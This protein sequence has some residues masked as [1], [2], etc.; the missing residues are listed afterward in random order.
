MLCVSEYV[1]AMM[2]TG[3]TT[4]VEYLGLFTGPHTLAVTLPFS[5]SHGK[6]I[7]I[8]QQE[9]ERDSERERSLWE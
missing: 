3:A 7:R 6:Y 5:F 9:Q 4:L 8:Q 2:F 1:T